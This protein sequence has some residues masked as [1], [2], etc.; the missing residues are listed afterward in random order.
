MKNLKTSAQ[1]T[2]AYK[3]EKCGVGKSERNH[4]YPIMRKTFCMELIR[5]RYYYAHTLKIYVIRCREYTSVQFNPSYRLKLFLK[6]K[7]SGLRK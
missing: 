1:A 2:L 4:I 3:I 5:K 7:F 6:K